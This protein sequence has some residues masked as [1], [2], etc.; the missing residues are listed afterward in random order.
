MTVKY[1]SSDLEII[2][3]EDSQ[4]FL[5]FH[6]P[7]RS[8]VWLSIKYILS[9]SKHEFHVLNHTQGPFV[10]TDFFRDDISSFLPRSLQKNI[11]MFM[12]GINYYIF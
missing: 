11:H 9:Y 5:K 10:N 3:L 2:I 4:H 12:Q 6:K 1:F 8:L 7:S